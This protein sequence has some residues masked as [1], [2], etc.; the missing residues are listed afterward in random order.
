MTSEGHRQN[1]LDSD[2]R[3]EGIGV[4]VATGGEVYATQNFC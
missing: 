4:Q 1:I 3:R 2:W